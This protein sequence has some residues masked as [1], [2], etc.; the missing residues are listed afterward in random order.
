MV[1]TRALLATIALVALVGCRTKDE[2]RVEVK[3]DPIASA[4]KSAAPSPSPSPSPTVAPPP[5]TRPDTGDLVAIPAGHRKGG[6]PVA[7]FSIDRTEVSSA[8]YEACVTAGSCTKTPKQM[9]C[10]HGD[11]KFPANCMTQPQAVAFCAWAG[12]RLPT[13]EEWDYAA[14]GS[15]GRRWPWGGYAPPVAKA[16]PYMCGFNST[17]YPEQPCEIGSAPKGVG[18]FGLLDMAGN[19]QEWTSTKGSDGFVAMGYCNCEA[20]MPGY[21]DDND[22]W[23]AVEKGWRSDREASSIGSAAG[24]RCAGDFADGTPVADAGAP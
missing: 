18:P 5:K 8:A 23:N 20:S 11:A 4:S 10:L 16:E 24:F 15:D 21:E 14:R 7:A 13:A 22:W 17:A 3:S 2:P 6:P 12:K 9:L 1:A 19:V